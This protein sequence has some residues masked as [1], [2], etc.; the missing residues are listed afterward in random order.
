MSPAQLVHLLLSHFLLQGSLVPLRCDSEEEPPGGSLSSSAWTKTWDMDGQMQVGR[1]S[2]RFCCCYC[3]WWLDPAVA[4]RRVLPPAAAWA[5]RWTV[6]AWGSTASPRICPEGL[7][8][9]EYWVMHTQTHTLTHTP[10][11]TAAAAQC[12]FCA[13]R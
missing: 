13:M 11:T 4:W 7:K 10:S 6:T 5:A 1:C 8:G 9:C 12:V 2:S 3:C